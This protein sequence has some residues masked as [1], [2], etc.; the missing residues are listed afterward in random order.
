MTAQAINTNAE[1]LRRESAEDVFYGQ[2]VINWA[3]WFVIAAGVI[4]VMTLTSTPA[5]LTVGIIPIV[6]LMVVNFYLHGRRLAQNPA[7][8]GLIAI[9]SML[10]LALITTVIA[11]G[12]APAEAGL[13]SQ[14]YVAYFPVIAAFGF[15]M[16]RRMT[17]VYTLVAMIA[18]A[19]TTLVV[20]T[21][22]LSGSDVS[23]IDFEALVTRLIGMA[24]VGGLASFFWWVQRNRRRAATS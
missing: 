8:R 13:G 24:A 5:E 16:P 12:P 23:W 9:S 4:L 2:V 22:I 3:R 14:F 18:Y 21:Q 19:V 1:F 10:D 20:N 15:V 11:I 6:G 7:N 17:V